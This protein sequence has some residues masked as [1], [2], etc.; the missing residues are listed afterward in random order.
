MITDE[1]SIVIDRPLE[2]VFA[3]VTDPHN[4]ALW[5]GWF[6][7]SEVTSNGPIGVGT[8]FRN[9]ATFLGKRIEAD[10]VVTSWEPN[11]RSCIRTTSG[12][13]LTTGC[14]SVEAVEGG[15]R[16]AQTIEASPGAFFGLAEHIVVRLGARQLEADLLM[17]KELLESGAVPAAA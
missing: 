12:P 16:F 6:I 8:T 2:E 10:A 13:I 3:F 9:V 4:N 15:T 7:E 5:C 14:R 1:R 11:R 17:L